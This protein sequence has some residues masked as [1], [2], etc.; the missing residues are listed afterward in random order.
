MTPDVGPTEAT[1]GETTTG[2][3]PDR[4][5]A[6]SAALSPWWAWIRT[7]VWAEAIAPTIALRVVLLAFG[8]LAVVVVQGVLIRVPSTRHMPTSL[9]AKP[10]RPRAWRSRADV[11][12]ARRLARWEVLCGTA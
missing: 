12:G 10:H 9:A 6:E 3:A 4:E 8:W 7:P 2:E 5:G 11:R 1:A